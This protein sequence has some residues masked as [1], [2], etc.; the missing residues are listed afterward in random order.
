MRAAKGDDA[1]MQSRAWPLVKR[2]IDHAAN[3]VTTLPPDPAAGERVLEALGITERSVLGALAVHTGG[4]HF[5]ENDQNGDGKPG[6]ARHALSVW[7]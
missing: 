3:D 7:W 4:L 2:W 5:C 6:I 1:A